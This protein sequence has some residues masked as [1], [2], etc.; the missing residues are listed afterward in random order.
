M[1]GYRRPHRY[2]K[3]KPIY[4]SRFF[5]LVIFILILFFSFFYFL[6]LTDFF[7][8]KEINIAGLQQ[9]SEEA[10]NSLVKSHLENKILFFSTKSI[11][12]VNS[13]KI[14]EEA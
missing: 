14:K 9:V 4:R 11:F 5:W 7:Q 12:S 8:I 2:K 13:N 6:F 3:R 1:K 10:L